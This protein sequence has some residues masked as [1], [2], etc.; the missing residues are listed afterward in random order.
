MPHGKV[1]YN[2]NIKCDFDARSHFSYTALSG[3]FFM[4]NHRQDED[5]QKW[6]EEQIRQ[7]T[8]K[9]VTD[10]EATLILAFALL[11]VLKQQEILNK[12]LAEQ[13]KQIGDVPLIKKLVFGAVGIILTAVIMAL[14]ALV[15]IRQ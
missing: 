8:D 15:V 3:S 13:Q 14:V 12:A 4:P 1:W 10:K 5:G 2:T 6:M 7:I 9:K 11:E